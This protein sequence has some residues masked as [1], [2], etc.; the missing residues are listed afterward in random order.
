MHAGWHR[1]H[2][3]HATMLFLFKS[4]QIYENMLNNRRETFSDTIM[5]M[6]NIRLL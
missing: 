2:I 3:S 6:T 4:N 1:K 5:N